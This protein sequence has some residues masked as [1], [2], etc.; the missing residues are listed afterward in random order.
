MDGVRVRVRGEAWDVVGVRPEA[1]VGEVGL[2]LGHQVV[3][4]A[5]RGRLGA[6]VHK[7]RDVAPRELGDAELEAGRGREEHLGQGWG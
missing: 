5:V 4:R 7:V 3:A 2:P 6:L 1:R